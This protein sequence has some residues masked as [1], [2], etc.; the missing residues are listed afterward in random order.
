M[1]KTDTET[2]GEQILDTPLNT[3]NAALQA[4]A[5][6][7][8]TETTSLL[9]QIIQEKKVNADSQTVEE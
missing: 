2:P 7:A 9:T 4:D 6:H 1:Q 8:E 3:T 5:R